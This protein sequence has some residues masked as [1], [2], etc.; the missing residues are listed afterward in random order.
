M[1]TAHLDRPGLAALSLQQAL[2]DPS[3]QRALA[4]PSLQR[5]LADLLNQ[6]DLVVRV[7]LA[8]QEVLVIRLDR[9]DA[10]NI[11]SVRMS[12]SRCTGNRI[13]MYFYDR[14]SA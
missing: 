11:L 13:H 2:V 1:R 4:G 7:C 5:A 9:Q 6:E 12:R 14:A 10:D 3:L 8:V